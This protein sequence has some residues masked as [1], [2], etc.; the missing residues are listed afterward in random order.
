MSGVG[1]LNEKSL[2]AQLKAWYAEPGDRAEVPVGRFVVDLVRGPL[3]IEIQTRNL[4]AMRAKLA[5]L[6]D[7]H[8]IRVVYP[9]A[10]VKWLSKVD[11]YGVPSPRRKSP[12][13]GRPLD[14]FGELVSIPTLVD[15]PNFE[16]EVVL[17]EELELRVHRPRQKRR[18]AGWATEE[19]SLEGIVEHVR[20]TGGSD[21]VGLLPELPDPWTTADLASAA[22]IR[23]R[24]SQ[25]VAYCLRKAGLVEQVDKV[26]NAAVYRFT[27]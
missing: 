24:L 14:L 25:Q 8:P 9:I 11:A 10:A 7:D 26:G 13:R 16:L 2:H 22:G 27:A 20:I 15:H 23:R 18:R 19:R 4:S 17:I 5:A 6:L 21:L 12:K 1:T 3:L